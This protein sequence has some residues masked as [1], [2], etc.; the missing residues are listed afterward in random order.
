LYEDVPMKGE[1]A[2]ECDVDKQHGE[3]SVFSFMIGVY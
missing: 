2:F 1:L 3:Q